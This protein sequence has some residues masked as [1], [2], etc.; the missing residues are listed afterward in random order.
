MGMMQ[1]Q[2]K[3]KVVMKGQLIQMKIT[4]QATDIGAAGAA[5]KGLYK[6]GA[7]AALAAALVFR[8]NL[9]AEWMLLRMSGIIKT[10]PSES[11]G[12]LID[13][14][15]L[16]QQNRLLGLTLLNL[17]DLVN[18][19]LV[20]LIFLALIA[21]LW[22]ASQSWMLL[23]GVL[24]FAGITV[25][26]ASNQAFTLLSLSSQYAAATVEA[27]RAMLLAAGQAA[28]AIHQNASYAGSGIYLS[29]LLV[30][31]AGLILSAAML[32]NAIFGKGT[33]YMGILANG[34]G[35]S[36]Y[37]V[38]VFA[39]ALDF[40]PISISAIFLLAWYLRVGLRLWSLGAYQ[41]S[42]PFNSW[43]L[44]AFALNFSFCKRHLTNTGNQRSTEL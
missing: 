38:L 19:A 7:A 36:Y 29:F 27:Q 10:G 42:F 43:R 23:A 35:L 34:L 3:S 44:C 18:Y 33:A 28:L 24:G 21:A 11:P 14:F 6:A 20:G 16:L 8:R 13:W 26:F 41:T 30:S 15:V 37:L 25:Y 12:T 32:R 17:F 31:A 9:D 39:P 4:D 2:C 1:S 5:W 22:R 40:I